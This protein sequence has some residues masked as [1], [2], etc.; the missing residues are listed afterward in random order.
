MQS[1]RITLYEV[2]KPTG[3]NERTRHGALHLLV[4]S[5]CKILKSIGDGDTVLVHKGHEIKLAVHD[6]LR[7]IKKV[8]L[9][10]DAMAPQGQ[11]INFQKENADA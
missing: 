4:I 8:D 7:V 2:S 1:V 11:H 10:D 5:E 3:L 9:E 6:K